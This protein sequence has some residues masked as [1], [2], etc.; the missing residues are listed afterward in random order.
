MTRYLST[1]RLCDLK[2][3]A[4][5]YAVTHAVY[6]AALAAAEDAFAK[7][8]RQRHR[9][10]GEQRVAQHDMEVAVTG[11]HTAALALYPTPAPSARDQPAPAAKP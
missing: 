4:A 3:A 2:E 9:L 11:L 5:R 7:N 1:E 8:S 10:A 6:A